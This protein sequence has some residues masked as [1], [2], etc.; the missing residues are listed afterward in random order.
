MQAS[1]GIWICVVLF[2]QHVR[3]ILPKM[4]LLEHAWDDKY[5]LANGQAFPNQTEYHL[6]Y[7]VS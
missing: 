5:L 3:G 6:D 4:T 1:A 7:R 2:Y